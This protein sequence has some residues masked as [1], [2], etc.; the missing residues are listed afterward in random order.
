LVNQTRRNFDRVTAISQ[1]YG[2][3]AHGPRIKAERAVSKFCRS[4]SSVKLV[5]RTDLKNDP[6]AG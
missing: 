4:F 2:N 3:G 1:L 5:A 6:P